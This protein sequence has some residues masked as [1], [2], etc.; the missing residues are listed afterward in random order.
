MANNI[1]SV[2]EQVDNQL[3]H[4]MALC[5]SYVEAD[6]LEYVGNIRALYEEYA[7]WIDQDNAEVL[8]CDEIQPVS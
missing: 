3:E 6:Q 8:W 4:I 5:E 7:E 1:K 2:Q